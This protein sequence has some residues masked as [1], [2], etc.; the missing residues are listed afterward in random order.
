MAKGKMSG[1]RK[2]GGKRDPAQMEE[3]RKKM[4][5]AFLHHFGA[6]G[7]RSAEVKHQKCLFPNGVNLEEDEGHQKLFGAIYK[8]CPK[9]DCHVWK[10]T[11]TLHTVFNNSYKA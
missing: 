4:K 8:F 10:S 1:I 3:F 9:F 11:K 7:P 5:G 6:E 2:Q